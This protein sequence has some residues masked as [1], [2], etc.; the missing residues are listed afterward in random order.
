[1]KGICPA[2]EKEVDIINASAETI[3]DV[4]GEKIN[5]FT[6]IFTCPECGVS[7]SEMDSE[8]DP[9]D[10][11]YREYRKRHGMLQPEEIKEFRKRYGLT[12]AELAKLL[13]WGAA[14]LPRYENGALQSDTHNKSLMMAMEPGNLL[15]LVTR[16]PE[17]LSDSKRAIIIRELK[18]EGKRRFSFEDILSE[19]FGDYEPDIMS[20]YV[21]LNLEKLFNAILYF[22]DG[23]VLK[24]KLNKLLFYSDFKYFKDHTVSITGARY[25]KLPY[26]PVLDNYDY[27]F[28]TLIHEEKKISVEEQDFGGYWGERYVSMKAFDP[29][30]FSEDEIQVMADVKEKF[31]DMGAKQI[32]DFSHKEKGYLAVD[33]SSYI[34]YGYAKDL[35]I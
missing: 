23:G 33:I 13:G 26:G 15:Q 9:L 20:G 16:T 30:L 11:A 27:Y 22:C 35:S 21:K 3:F 10:V 34:P 31:K 19:R 6:E 14:T 17:A 18:E 28:A 2:C 7:Y 29:A 4:R 24:T 1:M 12:Q 5:V 32:S 25:A 8:N